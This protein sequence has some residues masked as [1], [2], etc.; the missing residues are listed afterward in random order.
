MVS[1]IEREGFCDWECVRERECVRVCF[2][3]ESKGGSE[4]ERVCVHVCVCV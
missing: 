2:V 3:R 4:R 1:E